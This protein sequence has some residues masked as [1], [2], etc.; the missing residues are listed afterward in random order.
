MED[1]KKVIMNDDFD[2]KELDTNYWIPTYLPQ[3]SS[4]KTTIPSY[5]IEN[6]ILTLYIADEQEPWCSEWNGEVRVSNL[7]TGVYSGK[8]NS[9]QGQHHF[10]EGLIVREEQERKYTVTPQYCTLEFKARCHISKENVAA[11]WLIGI[12]EEEHQS[13][14]ICLFE[15]K[16]WNIDET[17]AI[18]GYGVHPF[19][20]N[21]IIDEFYEERF[22]IDVEE[23][24]VYRLDWT[25]ERIQFF[26]NDQLVKTIEQ[27]PCYPMQLMLNLYDLYHIKN[28]KNCFQI[29]YV[30]VYQ[31]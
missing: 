18:I 4:R 6:S 10:T 11:L 26:F 21:K 23:W 30:K 16:G 27:S 29:D 15:L 31:N 25:R 9:K 5:R 8:I 19:G 22:N 24:N 13:A 17:G 20:D 14:E 28:E 2:Q 1:K 7:Q 3:W 12:E